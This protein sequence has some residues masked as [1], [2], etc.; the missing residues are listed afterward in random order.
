MPLLFRLLAISTLVMSLVVS[1]QAYAVPA[2]ALPYWATIDN[3]DHGHRSQ[4]AKKRIT[5]LLHAPYVDRKQVRHYNRC[6]TT[7]AKRAY[8]NRVV[9]NGWAW[10]KANYWQLRFER[11]PA[12]W[13]AWAWSTGACESGNNPA[14][15]TGNGFYGAFQFMLSTW[16]A[17]GGAGNP[18]AQSWHYQAVIAIGL[19][20]REGTGHWPNCG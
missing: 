5:T 18:A 3:C 20:Q 8:L 6:V 10:R 17:A 9:Q 19:A 1:T 16:A 15:N 2:P 14:T 13:Q 7:R 4:V 12:G 11:L